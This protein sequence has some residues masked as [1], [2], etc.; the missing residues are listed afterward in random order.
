MQP[1]RRIIRIHSDRELLGWAL[2]RIT[3]HESRYVVFRE[4][5]GAEYP[6]DGTNR[7]P[8]VIIVDSRTGVFELIR[9]LSSEC[10]GVPII[11]WQR[12]KANEPLLNALDWGAAGV[13]HDNST[14]DDILA[15]LESVTNGHAWIPDSVAQAASRSRRCH[16]SRREGQLLG[17]VVQGLRNK[18]IAHYLNITEGTVKVYFSRLFEKLG[19]A[20]RYELALL[21]LR[22]SVPDSVLTVQEFNHPGENEPLNSIYVNRTLGFESSYLSGHPPVNAHRM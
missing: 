22:H 7:V 9:R 18:E 20:D 10:F 16:L 14:A 5:S 12:S 13:L 11:V 2:Q 3:E 1:D 19:V 17:L 15:C 8:S 21:G 6:N 4:G